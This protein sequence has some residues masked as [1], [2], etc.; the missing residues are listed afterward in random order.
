M[1]YVQDSHPAIIS[2]E[3]FGKAQELMAER[4]KSKG[5]LEGDREKYQNRYAL[6]GIIVCGNCG[7]KLPPSPKSHKPQ[8][9]KTTELL[10]SRRM[11]CGWLVDTGGR[12]WN[13]GCL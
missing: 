8:P 10:Q 13:V 1:Y 9:V 7:N 5:N 2:R 3:D 4:A 11:G 12:R 6:T